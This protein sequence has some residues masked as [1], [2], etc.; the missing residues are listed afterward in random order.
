MSD[1]IA[2]SGG[3]GTYTVAAWFQ[4]TGTDSQTY[5]AIFGGKDA[6]GGTEWFIG[7]NSGNTALGVQD[8]NYRSNFVA[9]P[10]IFDAAGR[11]SAHS[12]IYTRSAASG[13]SY[14]GKVYIDGAFKASA[15][16]TGV[17]NQEEL[18]IGKEFGGA[19]SFKGKIWQAIILK[20]EFSA[21][22]AAIL[23]GRLARND[24]H[25][26]AAVCPN[27]VVAYY[28]P[29]ISPVN[30]GVIKDI[31]ARGN[32]GTISGGVSSS[33]DHLV[34]SSGS[35]NT[36]LKMSDLITAS[37]GGGAY[38]VA[39]WFQ[40][41]G[42]NSRT[43]SAIFGGKDTSGGTQWFVGKNSGN[44]ALGVQDGNYISSFDP[45]PGIFDSAGRVSAHSIVFT[46]SAVSA[47][48][49]TGK[50][51]IDGILKSTGS[52]SGVNGGE[53]LHVGYEYEGG[54]YPFIGKI[55]QAIIMSAEL[56]A[57]QVSSLHGTLAA[58]KSYCPAQQPITG[59]ANFNV[60]TGCIPHPLQSG[61]SCLI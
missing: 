39:A 7:K 22:E 16:F 12:I 38:T 61:L 36:G 3:A 48:S 57:S 41:T 11:A 23:H 15:S 55:W 28:N 54:G 52:F 35:I 44:T 20:T 33:G 56:S 31:S 45:S 21:A 34:F 10:G 40:Y 14:T 59:A 27:S 32:D 43:Y 1:V 9:S 42:T 5:S 29:G 47:G 53:E 6:T 24:L 25:C 19:Y 49:Y 60:P 4:Y 2:A 58:G 37:G 30:G 26:G 18:T 51:Y 8:G 50:V 46:R 17:N 13:G